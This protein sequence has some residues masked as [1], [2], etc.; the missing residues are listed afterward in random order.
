MTQIFS[1]TGFGRSLGEYNGKRI[2]IEVKTLNSKSLDLNLR[3]PSYYREK[4]SDIRS[5]VSEKM[6]RGKVD[7]QMY[8][9]STACEPKTN[10]NQNI[11]ASYY[12]QLEEIYTSLNKTIGEETMAS[13]TRFPDVMETRHE[14]L[15]A[16]EWVVIK[17][18]IEES[19]TNCLQFRA[20]EGLSLRN[21]LV[22]K[23]DTINELKEQILP[24]EPQRKETIKARIQKS[25]AELEE[26]EKFDPNRFEQELIYYIEKLDINEERVRLEQH[27]KYFIETMNLGGAIGRKLGFITQEIGREI[28]TLGSKANHSEI[29]KLVIL[30][31][32]ELEQMKEQIL[33][34]L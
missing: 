34:I 13:I 9:E 12:K 32:D 21:D 24:L 19:I 14:E 25:I 31:K 10:I 27:L 33:N 22:Q 26:P 8:V 15:E 23:I 4:E 5:M 11:F 3:I 7:F 18:L 28:N 30:M 20:T 2:T 29:Q 6:I 16:D 1:M 17:D